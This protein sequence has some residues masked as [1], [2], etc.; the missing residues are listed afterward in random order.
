VSGVTLIRDVRIADFV[1]SFED[2]TVD[3]SGEVIVQLDVPSDAPLGAYNVEVDADEGSLTAPS[4]FSVVRRPRFASITPSELPRGAR[5]TVVLQGDDLEALVEASVAPGGLAVTSGWASDS[6]RIA[7]T[8]AV[9]ETAD[10]PGQQHRKQQQQT[11]DD[12]DLA[13]RCTEVQCVQRQ[14]H[15]HRIVAGEIPSE[16][17]D[18][19]T[20]DPTGSFVA[21]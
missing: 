20:F 6:N 16:C 17:R 4:L 14:Q 19:K 18:A 8:V 3:G 21:T 15:P 11:A 2:R 5:T 7:F 1:V 13:R 9:G 10:K 12:A